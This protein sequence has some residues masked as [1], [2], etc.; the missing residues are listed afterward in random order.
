MG[1]GTSRTKLQK[2]AIE[3]M[4]TVDAR[5]QAHAREHD[6]PKHVR[7]S[8]PECVHCC[9]NTSGMREASKAEG[10]EPANQ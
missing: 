7:N 9:F 4:I 5:R 1:R 10:T 3:K 8:Q 6:H 2:E